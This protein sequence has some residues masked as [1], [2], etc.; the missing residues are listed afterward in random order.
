ME[1]SNQC[2]YEGTLFYLV[3][4][5]SLNECGFGAL[6]NFDDGIIDTR[7]FNRTT[8]IGKF[9]VVGLVERRLKNLLSVGPDGKI[10]VVSDQYHL[11]RFLSLANATREHGKDAVI[12][13]VVFRLVDN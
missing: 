3:F 12:V 6:Q 1:A 11:P 5:S 13:E 4:Q 2:F 8:F 7:V 9:V 10:R